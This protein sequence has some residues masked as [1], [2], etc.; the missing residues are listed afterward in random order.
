MNIDTARSYATES[1]LEAALL[2]MGLETAKPLIVCN[3]EGR[4]T[5]IFTAARCAIAQL[6]VGIPPHHGFFIV[7]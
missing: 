6:N 2:K 5:P 3:R 7:N 4:F 1:G